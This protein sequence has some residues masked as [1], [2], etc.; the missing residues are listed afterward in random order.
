[1]QVVRIED[2]TPEQLL[3]AGDARSRFDLAL[4]FSTKYQPTDS[5]FDRWRL[6]QQWKTRYFGYHVDMSPEAAASVLGGRLVYQRRKQEQLVGVIE[7]DKIE[8]A[9]NQASGFTL[10][11]SGIRP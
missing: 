5:I 2:F 1:M 8:E 11:A 4:V 10:Q 6:W 9:R 7:M 3:S